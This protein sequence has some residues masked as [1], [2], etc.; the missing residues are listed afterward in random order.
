[1]HTGWFEKEQFV[2]APLTL[3]HPMYFLNT[4][5][6]GGTILPYDKYNSEFGG[7]SKVGL[8]NS[9]FQYQR[10]ISEIGA[11]KD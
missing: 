9:D 8:A 5:Y 4:E 6:Q 10:E 3:F 1:M 2:S 11:S 7:L